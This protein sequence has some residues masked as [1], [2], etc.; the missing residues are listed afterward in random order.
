MNMLAV[1]EKASKPRTRSRSSSPP[2]SPS[3]P[4]HVMLVNLLNPFHQALVATAKVQLKA[5]DMIPVLAGT[6]NIDVANLSINMFTNAE[7][8]PLNLREALKT[9]TRRTFANTLITEV[10]SFLEKFHH[11]HR[12]AMSEEVFELLSWRFMEHTIKTIPRE[13]DASLSESFGIELHK[14]PVHLQSWSCVQHC[15]RV[16]FQLEDMERHVLS[17]PDENP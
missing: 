5:G 10:T 12:I 3:A 6:T 9:A 7:L 2:S 11:R 13:M 14:T 4:V 8:P 1:L 16:A 17:E 15:V